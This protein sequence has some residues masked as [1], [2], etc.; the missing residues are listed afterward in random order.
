MITV[1]D[2]KCCQKKLDQWKRERNISLNQLKLNHGTSF[3]EI[4]ETTA[5]SMTMLERKKTLQVLKLISLESRLGTNVEESLSKAHQV[6]E[7]VT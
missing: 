7:K 1:T 5:N 4:M 6:L 2:E 3:A